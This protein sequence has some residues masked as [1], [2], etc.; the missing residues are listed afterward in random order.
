MQCLLGWSTV[1]VGMNY[2][3]L[4]CTYIGLGFFQ[5]INCFYLLGLG[6]YADTFK[7]IFY[8]R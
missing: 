2:V 4:Q 1:P 6:L 8:T 5:Q 7:I 3:I